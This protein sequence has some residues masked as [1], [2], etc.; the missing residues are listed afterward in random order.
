MSNLQMSSTYF[1]AS[2][3]CFRYLNFV[4]VDLQKLVKVTECNFHNYTIIWQ[5]ANSTNV[6]HTFCASSYSFRDIPLKN[7][8]SKSRSMSRNATFAIAPLDGTCRNLQMSPSYLY[9]RSYRV[10]NI[11]F[12]I[13]TSRK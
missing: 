2:S 5:R 8:P 9:S 11:I 1:C 12:L 13:F 7:C 6:F 4:I 3:Y 10:R